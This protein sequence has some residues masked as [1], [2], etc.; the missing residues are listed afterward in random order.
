MDKITKEE[1][2][3]ELILQDLKHH[4]LVIGLDR[5][6]LDPGYCHFL[7]IMELVQKLMKVP[8]ERGDD[9]ST[10]YHDYMQKCDD[11]PISPSGEEMRGLAGECYKCL[12]E[13]Y[14]V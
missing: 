7:G 13:K 6:N 11:F 4:Q 14:Q 2:I 10:D 1:F 3:V 8:E 9:F 12:K 5:L